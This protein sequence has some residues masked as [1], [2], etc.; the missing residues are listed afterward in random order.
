MASN[1]EDSSSLD[2]AILTKNEVSIVVPPSR[3]TVPRDSA[4]SSPSPRNLQDDALQHIENTGGKDNHE[5]ILGNPFLSKGQAPQDQTMNAV[6]AALAQTN[7]LIQPQNDRIGALEQK[8]RS[9]TPPGRK[10]RSQRDVVP[11]KRPRSPSPRENAGPSSKKGSSDHRSRHR[12]QSPRP[13]RRSRS[14]PTKHDDNRRR[15]RRSRSRSSTPSASDDEEERRGPLSHS[16]LEAPLPAGLEKPLPLGTYDRA[17]DPDEHIENIDA[18]LDYKGVPGAIKCRLLP[19]TP[20]KGAMTWYKS[21]PN[22]SIT[23]WKVLEKLFSRH[24]TASRRHPRSEASLEAIIQGKD[25]S[26]RAYIERFNKEVVQV[27]TTVHMKKF[28]LERGL[29]PRSDFAKAVGIETPATLNEFFLKAQAYIQ[30]E[31]KEAAYAVHNSRQEESNKNSRQDDSRWGTD[32]KKDDKGQDPMD[33]KA[34]AGKFREYTPLNTS[35]EHI[36][37]ECANAEFQ[38]GKVR[39]PKTMPARPNMDKSKF[40]RFH[41]G[42]GH[43]TEDCIHLKDAIEILIREGHLKQYAKKQEA[44]KEAKPIIEEKPVDDTPA[45]QVAM[46]ITRPEDFYL[47]DWAKSTTAPSPH[48]PWE[49][50]P[51]AMVISG[52]GFS[53]LTVGSVK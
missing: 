38:T 42:H 51:S 33:Y 20:R 52:G 43:N 22:E 17:I 23:L 45:M 15:H 35:R 53:K 16:I 30:Y 48:S 19:T 25:E 41:K 39:F 40:C 4:T 50:F 34:L 37:N 18:L 49:M 47:H 12:S 3:N 2:A 31:E 1:N 14:P 27:S 29:R 8:R 9:K 36:L 28:L 44:A 46:S 11:E 6:L 26:L 5:E 10:H 32:K 7:T 13:K 24:F 21:L